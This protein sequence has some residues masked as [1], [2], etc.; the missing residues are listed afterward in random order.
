[1]NIFNY[2]VELRIPK[3]DAE[4]YKERLINEGFDD[5]QSLKEDATHEDLKAISMKPGHIKRLMRELSTFVNISV[6]DWTVQDCLI[7]LKKLTTDSKYF[8][9]CSD[10]FNKFQIDGKKLLL[11]KN[12]SSLV[13]ILGLE[14]VSNSK[15]IYSHLEAL[16][17]ESTGI[18]NGF[19]KSSSFYFPKVTGAQESTQICR[20]NSV[21]KLEMLH[22]VDVKLQPVV[23]GLSVAIPAAGETSSSGGSSKSIIDSFKSGHTFGIM[24]PPPRKVPITQPYDMQLFGSPPRG[25]QQADDHLFV[26]DNLTISPFGFDFQQPDMG[27]TLAASSIQHRSLTRINAT[28]RSGG[29]VQCT[30]ESIIRIRKIGSGGSGTVFKAIYEPTF[31][32]L[33]VKLIEVGETT[34]RKEILSELKALYSI[35]KYNLSVGDSTARPCAVIAESP[36]SS[37]A[38]TPLLHAVAMRRCA[39]GYISDSGDEGVAAVPASLKLKKP[40]PHAP[41]PVVRQITGGVASPSASG[42]P[43]IVK[44]YDAYLDPQSGAAYL[45]LEYLRGGSLQD[46]MDRGATF[47]DQELLVVAYSVLQ[48]LSVLHARNI[49]HRDIKVRR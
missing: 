13:Q 34:G 40:V 38:D 41:A 33:A 5:L 49:V 8:D 43:Y 20:K 39:S 28:E 27:K 9:H 22:S 18:S 12:E 3:E 21:E 14:F 37:E 17:K 6:M 30:R 31:E 23:G 2:L 48:A 10:V 46:L 26:Q 4:I 1:M 29:P 36:L 44:F 11:F 35:S 19:V 15:G 42:S 47:H 7:W 24:L 16:R 45:V 32:V 25:Q